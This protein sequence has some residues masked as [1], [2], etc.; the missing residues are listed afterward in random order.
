MFANNIINSLI[1]LVSKKK[2]VKAAVLTAYVL[3][4]LGFAATARA[5]YNI[6]PI[7]TDNKQLVTQNF[8]G[9]VVA[10]AAGTVFLVT[11]SQN[12]YR[13][14]ANVDL[15]D[16]SGKMVEIL[17]VEVKYKTGPVFETMALPVVEDTD[18]APVLVVLNITELQ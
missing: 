17:G 16:Y 1:S 2:N 13:L 4:V 12:V 5:E 15:A 14:E 18:S 9:E 7:F 10:D 11:E 8:V 3:L 6:M